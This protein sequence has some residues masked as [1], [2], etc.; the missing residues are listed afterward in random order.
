MGAPITMQPP[1]LVI[2]RGNSGSG[3]TTTAEEVRRRFGR[4]A[5]LL[6]QDHLRRTVLGEHDSSHV[7]PV[8]PAFIAAT[9]RTALDLGYHVILEG[10]LH[11]ERYASA[12]HQ[13]ITDHPGPASVFYL[14]VS[15]DET[16]RRHRNRSEPVPVTPAQMHQW[17]TP[18]D[19]LHRVD[20]IVIP[21]THT[22]DQTVAAILDASGLTHAVPQTPCPRRCRRCADEADE[23]AHRSGRS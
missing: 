14:D 19:L 9:A 12:L 13:L 4:G 8:A 21:E 20:E 18:R 1:T 16:V 15:F 22:F 10:I 2:I 17:Y 6:E 23:A 5:A 7:D 3:K 11:T